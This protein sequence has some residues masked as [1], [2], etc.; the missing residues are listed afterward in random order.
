MARTK[1]LNLSPYITVMFDDTCLMQ[2]DIY[3]GGPLLHWESLLF[4]SVD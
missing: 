3:Y 1:P 4:I 2:S